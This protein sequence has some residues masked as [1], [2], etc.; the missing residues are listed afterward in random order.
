MSK[1]VEHRGH[2]FKADQRGL[3]SRRLRQVRHVVDHR[4]RSHELRLPD[5]LAHP[6]ATILVVALVVIEVRERQGLAV[7]VAHLI[8]HHVRV[9]HGDVRPAL[10]ADAV[11]LV[12]RVEH[13]ILQDP[14]QLEVWLHL[15]L[16]QV[17]FRLAHLFGIEVP[18]PGLQLET[19]LRL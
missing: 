3:T 1:L 5:E 8:D 6:R 16:I 19:A 14:V 2:V 4:Q 9:I 17:V 11:Q 18:I 15:R 13:A 7:R 12:R 10:E